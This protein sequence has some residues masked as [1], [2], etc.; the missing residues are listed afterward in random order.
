MGGQCKHFVDGGSFGVGAPHNIERTR[1]QSN[2]SSL[3]LASIYGRAAGRVVLSENIA[4]SLL[5]LASWNL[6]D[7][8]LSWKFKMEPKCCKSNPLTYIMINF[9]GHRLSL[10]KMNLDFDYETN[11]AE[12]SE[13]THYNLDYMAAGWCKTIHQ[14]GWAE[15][16]QAQTRF[17]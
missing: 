12:T 8:Q 10:S 11:L 3:S 4:T 16:C 5:H 6:T 13:L 7:S 9:L 1:Y 15:L 2:S 17:S 14:Q